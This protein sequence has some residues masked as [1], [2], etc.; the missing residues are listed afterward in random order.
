MAG[1]WVL[2]DDR[3]CQE[4]RTF[5]VLQALIQGTVHIEEGTVWYGVVQSTVNRSC[6][7]SIESLD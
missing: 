2:T 1:G 3:G 6:V 5:V 4:G 7:A